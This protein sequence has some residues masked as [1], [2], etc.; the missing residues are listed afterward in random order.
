MAVTGHRSAQVNV[1]AMSKRVRFALLKMD[2]DQRWFYV[3]VNG[4]VLEHKTCIGIIT[5]GRFDSE[6]PG[7]QKAKK[8][9]AASSP[10]HN[11]VRVGGSRA[12]PCLDG[13]E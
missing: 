5:L 10:Q 11:Y 12:P 2:S 8:S 3:G 7:S 1:D 6:L 4:H 9:H 13:S